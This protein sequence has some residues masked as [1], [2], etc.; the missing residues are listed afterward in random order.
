MALHETH[1]ICPNLDGRISL[2]PSHAYQR[3][4]ACFSD[5]RGIEQQAE[6]PPSISLVPICAECVE[7]SDW[8]AR[9]ALLETSPEA[10]GQSIEHK[11][12]VAT[13]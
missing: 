12:N 1:H 5:A 3:T 6:R 9:T 10:R 8:D 13:F 2:E 7:G 4:L 11:K